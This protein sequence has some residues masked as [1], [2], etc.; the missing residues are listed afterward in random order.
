MTMRRKTV[1]AEIFRTI[2]PYD[3]RLVIASK[4]GSSMYLTDG[5]KNS[6]D[7]EYCYTGYPYNYNN[8][9]LMINF[10]GLEHYKA[11]AYTKRI[12]PDMLMLKL[13]TDGSVFFAAHAEKHELFP[14][15]LFIV[16]RNTDC[17]YAPGSAGFCR[18]LSLTLSG[19]MLDQM[20]LNCTLAE[21]DVIKLPH[22]KEIEAKFMGAIRLLKERGKDFMR[23]TAVA[24]F[25]LILCLSEELKHEKTPPELVKV[26]EFSRKNLNR[27]PSASEFAEAAECYPAKLN[28]LFRRKLGIT[29]VA[30]HTRQ[31]L[32]EAEYHLLNS[33]YSIKEIADMLGYSSATYFSDD[34]KK[35]LSYS[36]REFRKIKIAH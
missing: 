17:E 19:R 26:L 35:H 24:A 21:T 15:E 23:K 3:G 16:H 29:P 14:G 31:R 6:R 33:C 13:V 22:P 8:E 34:F 10:G 4:R 27:C 30:Y 9:T 2:F 7:K 20:F 1:N 12:N 11:E 5:L 18:I 32:R 36:P 25:D 28:T